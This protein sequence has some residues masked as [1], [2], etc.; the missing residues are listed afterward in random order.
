M[1]GF[2]LS[3]LGDTISHNFCGN[4]AATSCVGANISTLTVNV[5]KEVTLETLHPGSFV[6]SVRRSRAR[7][8]KDRSLRR[9]SAPR[10][11]PKRVKIILRIPEED[12]H[13]QD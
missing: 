1:S 6:H 8:A 3:A 12:K 4:K 5:W 9:T 13:A 10:T 2:G 7:R 11:P